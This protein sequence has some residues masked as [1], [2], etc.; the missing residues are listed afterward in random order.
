[1]WVFCVVTGYIYLFGYFWCYDWIYLSFFFCYDWIYIEHSGDIRKWEMK[2][3]IYFPEQ[4]RK[5]KRLTPKGGLKMLLHIY[6]ICLITSISLLFN[7]F[8]K[9][10]SRWL[11][12]VF[13]GPYFP[14]HY[15][16][17]YYSRYP[18]IVFCWFLV[19]LMGFKWQSNLQMI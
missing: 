12:E 8:M 17:S 9:F 19:M 18:L 15:L 13:I 16:T 10:F 7:I 14:M 6:K 2:K 4:R 1:M 3:N 11:F 5:F